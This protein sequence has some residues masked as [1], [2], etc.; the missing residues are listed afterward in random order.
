M[1]RISRLIRK[2]LQDVRIYTN[3]LRLISRQVHI[4]YFVAN[5]R[6]VYTNEPGIF[7]KNSYTAYFKINNVALIMLLL[8]SFQKYVHAL[9]FIVYMCGYLILLH[10]DN[11]ID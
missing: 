3:N 11:T 1:V 4:V 8:P 6:P 7:S 9:E 2:S 5:T 10:D